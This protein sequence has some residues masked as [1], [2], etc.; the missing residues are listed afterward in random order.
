MQWQGC[1]ANISPPPFKII[2]RENCQKKKIFSNET[3][4]EAPNL[5]EHVPFVS[6]IS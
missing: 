1:W 6:E 4:M 2:V 5:S 3:M